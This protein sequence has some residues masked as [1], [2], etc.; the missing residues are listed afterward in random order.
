MTTLE[1]LRRNQ[2]VEIFEVEAD[3]ATGE[4]LGEPKATGQTTNLWDWAKREDTDRV[5]YDTYVYDSDT[6]AERALILKWA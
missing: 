4:W 3:A 6:Q 2:I 1:A 5:H